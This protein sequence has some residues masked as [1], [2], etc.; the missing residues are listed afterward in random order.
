[1]AEDI[2]NEVEKLGQQSAFYQISEQGKREM[3]REVLTVW[4]EQ[5]VRNRHFEI[6]TDEELSE[7]FSEFV[8]CNTGSFEFSASDQDDLASLIN[9]K[10]EI[11][12]NA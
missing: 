8:D 4:E 5:E 10:F 3:I 7:F 12:R 1:M 2:L 11:R 9:E 6:V